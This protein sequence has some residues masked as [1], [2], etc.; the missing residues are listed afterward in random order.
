VSAPGCGR[1]EERCAQKLK[2]QRKSSKKSNF[3]NQTPCLG[4]KAKPRFPRYLEIAAFFS[5]LLTLLKPRRVHFTGSE[6]SQ[7]GKWDRSLYNSISGIGAA[8]TNKIL[9]FYV[10][11]C[12]SFPASVKLS[13]HVNS[14]R[15][16]RK[17]PIRT[18]TPAVPDFLSEPTT[19]P[20]P[21]GSGDFSS[22]YRAQNNRPRF[23]LIR[24]NPAGPIAYANS[25]PR[26]RRTV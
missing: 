25:K 9:S 6:Q 19:V 23:A 20:E 21:I 3:R 22:F 4:T 5:A 8:D 14:A 11:C 24:H 10:F 1:G 18:T 12:N 7:N 26:S 13:E 17:E 2:N 15:T 16:S